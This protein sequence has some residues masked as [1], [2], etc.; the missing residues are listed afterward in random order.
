MAER[1]SLISDFQ[2][3]AIV[4]ILIFFVIIILI[5][6]G[7]VF[8]SALGIKEHVEMKNYEREKESERLRKIQYEEDKKR[9]EALN[10]KQIEMS[11]REKLI[12]NEIKES[13]KKIQIFYDMHLHYPNEIRVYY[14]RMAAYS[15]GVMILKNEFDEKFPFYCFRDAHAKGDNWRMTTRGED[16]NIPL[17]FAELINE[18]LGKRY[19]IQC[20]NTKPEILEDD[21]TVSFSYNQEYVE[22]LINQ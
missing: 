11:W 16:I 6:I 21:I 13:V 18:R 5:I 14:D 12:K 10:R 8:F 9:E 1:G 20:I 15:S 3:I 7:V 17:L 2:D 19:S 4:V 22:L